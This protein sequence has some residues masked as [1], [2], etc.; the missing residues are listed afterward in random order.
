MSYICVSTKADKNYYYLANSN[1]VTNGNGTTPQQKRIYLGRYFK[2]CQKI[3]KMP[4]DEQLKHQYIEQIKNKEQQLSPQKD[5]F[6]SKKYQC[7][8]ID[9][10]WYYKLR[11]NDS[12]HRNR[13]PYP[14]MKIEQILDLPI[15]HL[16]DEQGAIVWLWFTNNHMTEA[17]MCLEKWGLE[18]KTILTWV[19]I[20]KKG[21]PRIG[22]GHW[23]RNCTEHCILATKGKVNSFSY[24][25]TL[26]NQ[27]TILQAPRREH[28]RKPDE[29]F[30]LVDQL[31]EGKS[32]LEMFARQNRNGWEA[33]GNETEK[34]NSLN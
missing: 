2:A 17:N 9:P 3:Q 11:K 18:L 10:P 14:P 19:K 12:T 30:S 28:S 7:I 15:D 5:I 27:S 6:P 22:T 25:K 33:W 32:K 26:T 31:C 34:F 23:L 20:S 4:V 21:T 16:C 8:V 29:F 24:L 13:I 1:R